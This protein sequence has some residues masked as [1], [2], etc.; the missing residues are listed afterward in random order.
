M[1]VFKDLSDRIT[2]INIPW[3]GKSGEQ[4]EDFISK[5]LVGGMSYN[6]STLTI[7]GN[8]T[9]DEDGSRNVLASTQVTVETPVYS[10]GIL[11]LA[12][13]ING[14]SYTTGTVT[15]QYNSD[16]RVELAVATYYISSTPTAG[17]VDS[18]L[19]VKIKISYGGKTKTTS[20][21]PYSKSL[22]TMD[23]DTPTRVNINQIIDGLI[24]QIYLK[25]RQ[26][27]RLLFLLLIIKNLTLCQLLLLIR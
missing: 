19:P 24:L 12:V 4:I 6:N 8:E 27:V 22:F 17:D 14:I 3:N 5:N 1:A 15:M 11:S 25:I 18:T 20:V 9:N 13:R 26:L 23:G 16:A 2:D 21:N 10:Q 7:Y